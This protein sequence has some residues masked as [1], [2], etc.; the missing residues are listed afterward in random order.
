MWKKSRGVNTFWSRCIVKWVTLYLTPSVITHYDR[1]IT[2][3]IVCHN[4]WHSL[5][6]YGQNIVMTYIVWTVVTYIACF[7][8]WLWHLHKSVKTRKT[9]HTRQNIPLHTIAYVSTVCLCYICIYIYCNLPYSMIN[10]HA[11]TLMSDM[12]LT[13]CSVSDDWA[14]CRSRF[15]EQDKTPSFWLMTGIRACTW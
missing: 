7:Y 13:Q 4:S 15:Q 5:L 8:G 2:N 14:E 9:Y 1:A 10:Y 12:H 11:H 6:K 3:F